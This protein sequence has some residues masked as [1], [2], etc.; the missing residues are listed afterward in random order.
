MF[1]SQSAPKTETPKILRSVSLEQGF[2][3][4][5]EK[6]STGITATSLSDFAAKLETVDVISVFFHYPRGDFQKWINDILGD[7]DLADRMCF[8]QIGLSGEK[9]REQLLRIIQKRIAEL[10]EQYNPKQL[11]GTV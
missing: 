10:K 7:T 3:F 5:T 9:L 6:G 11:D 4:S 1:M 8:V 2:R